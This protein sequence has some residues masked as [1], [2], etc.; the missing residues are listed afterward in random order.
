MRQRAV[1]SFNPEAFDPIDLAV[2]AFGVARMGMTH[3]DG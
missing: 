1:S 2:T 3:I